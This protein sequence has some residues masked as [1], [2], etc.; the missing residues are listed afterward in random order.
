VFAFD[1]ITDSG[2]GVPR[3]RNEH[4]TRGLIDVITAEA[5]MTIMIRVR[6]GFEDALIQADNVGDRALV[7]AMIRGIAGLCG[8]P[9]E[10]TRLGV[11]DSACP[12][13][14]ARRIHRW[15][16]SSFRDFFRAKLSEPPILLD[17]IDQATGL[18]GLAQKLGSVEIPSVVS[19][20]QD[21]TS[22]INGVVE[23]L[24]REIVG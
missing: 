22:L 6:S 13:G 3:P 20:K 11:L 24:V 23:K 8:S 7:E 14:G 15:T 4:E 18:L 5:S 19:G 10:S 1:E 9:S 21:C 12:R 16:T 17:P 2:V